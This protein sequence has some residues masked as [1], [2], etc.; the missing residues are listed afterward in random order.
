MSDSPVTIGRDGW[1]FLKN[2]T[3]RVLD[4]ISGSY[5]LPQDFSARWAELFSYRLRQSEKYGFRYL[6]TV[7]PDKEVVYSECLPDE[8]FLSANRPIFEVINSIP[9][10]LNFCYLIDDLINHKTIKDVYSKGDTHWN[11]VGAMIGFNR[12]ASILGI[13]LVS[14]EEIYERFL[15]IP[16]D[17]SSKIG[18]SNC[19]YKIGM[20]RK[21]Y[22][23][24]EKN[25]VTNLG[26]RSIFVNENKDLP[27]C[28]LFRDSFASHQVE[29]YASR[30]SKLIC[31]WQ[32][33]IDYDV[34]ERE[35][36]DFVIQ[37]QVE[38]FLVLVPD[39]MNGLTNAQ[40]ESK[41]LISKS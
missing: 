34:I 14:S 18:L 41:K 19:S 26:Q 22:K 24:I 28:I 20:K 4:Q 17:L 16:G 37:Q 40:Y 12:I 11:H 7:V 13:P 2:D 9:E 6:Y 31:L 36:P 33:N 8:I 5:A 39:D 10:N 29:F 1:L 21:S 3:N 30:F 25:S 15:E 38:R 35:K 27:S 32:P 23:L